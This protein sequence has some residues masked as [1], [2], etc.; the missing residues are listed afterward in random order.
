MT[1][2][3][4][5]VLR[6]PV[7][8]AA[9]AL[10]SSVAAD[11][12]PG[13]YL[14]ARQA[15]IE[16]DY[17]TAALYFQQALLSDPSNRKLM[18]Q[19]LT[20]YLGTGQVE[21]AARIAGPLNAAGGNT[22]IGNIALMSHAAKTGDW[23]AIFEMIEAGHEVGPLLDSLAQAWAFV[24][25][26]QMD[27]ALQS[28]DEL[29]ETQGLRSIGLHHKALALALVG[30]LEGA[31][32]LYALPPTSGIAPN[33][34]TV[35]SHV[36]TLAQLDRFEEA[37]DL[38]DRAFSSGNRDSQLDA[39][40]ADVAA[41]QV[42]TAGA[43]V[44]RPAEGIGFAFLSLTEVLQGEANESYLLLYAQAARHISPEDPQALMSVARLLIALDQ[45]TQ[46]AR[47][48]ALV[49]PDDPAFYSAEVG[50]AEALRQD[51]RLDQAI[52]VLT[53]L[54]RA[55]PAR[56]L[57]FASLGDVHRQQQEFDAANAAYDGA[58]GLYDEDDQSRWWLLYSRGIT[59]ER[60]DMWPE[61]EADFRAAL[62]LQPD[63]PSVLNYLGYSIVDRGQ[64]AKYGEA[65]DMIERAVAARPDSGA[66]TDSL[67]WVYYKLGRY[68]EAVTPMERAAELEPSDPIISDHLGDIYWMVGRLTEARF[69]WR[70]ALSFGPEETEADRI[71]RKLEV[72]L[73]AVY[74]E[75]GTTPAPAVELANDE[76]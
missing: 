56:P 30:D 25:K 8:A 24:G 44:S 22:Q 21:S 2:R 41:G 72:G 13:A 37:R 73:D 47:T 31:E 33:R 7:A 11:P 66:I 59:F 48:F 65:L 54:T 29:A 1:P 70:R 58:L 16:G 55:H 27:R 50:R 32:A 6:G 39:V 9:I 3:L 74:A 38:L 64:S 23:D 15:G 14:A 10:T 71:R 45:N 57:A 69:Q 68:Q 18:E 35:L 5:L 4:T 46:A 53:Q 20:S 40:F 67:A 12:D 62:A 36:R 75:E 19:T 49:S 43:L 34:W 26:G 42:P 52:E 28:F 63:N 61:A 60:M 17:A 76:G 51:G